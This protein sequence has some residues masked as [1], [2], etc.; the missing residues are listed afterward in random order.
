[1]LREKVLPCECANARYPP[2]VQEGRLG[3][4]GMLQ[5]ARSAAFVCP[6][7]YSGLG[8]EICRLRG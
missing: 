5:T 4:P 1:M 8:F 2:P 3:T 6:C 7:L